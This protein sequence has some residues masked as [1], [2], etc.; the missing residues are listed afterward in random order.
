MKLENWFWGIYV[1][2]LLL[3]GWGYYDGTAVGY[4]RFGGY[5]VLWALVGILGYSVFG[6]VVK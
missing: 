4:R 3:G 1:L 5:F 6:S 2:C